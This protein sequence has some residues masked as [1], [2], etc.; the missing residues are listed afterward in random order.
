[1]RELKDIIIN[2]VDLQTILDNHKHWIYENCKGWENM[3]ANLSDA[4]LSDANLSGANLRY[5]NLSGADLRYADLRY[6]NLSGA[7]LSGAN[8]RYADLSGTNL[9]DANLS[10]AN[11]S[12]ANLSGADLRYAN[13]SDANLRM[14][15]NLDTVNY[16]ESTAMFSLN[17]PEEG[18]F[19][20]FKKADGIINDDYETNV[21]VKLQI[22]E[23]AKRSSATTRKCRC[24]KAVVLG[25][26]DLD[27]NRLPDDIMVE[28]KYA[29][30]FMYKVGE[31][32]EPREPYEENR[33]I[34]CA[35]G[36]HFF[37]TFDEAVNY[38]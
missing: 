10:D 27:H 32:I 20:G 11:L 2:G 8:L 34:E 38:L 3:K 9:S 24:S 30:S 17:C 37:M 36:I 18:S 21:I 15:K 23:D 35:S 28:S 4:N 25:F 19:I 7:D 14:T 1:M 29:S 33:W 5:A 26:Y 22:T 31:I 13:L 6:A 12:G 16:N